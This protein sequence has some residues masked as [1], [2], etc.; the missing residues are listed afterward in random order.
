[1]IPNR[2]SK[3]EASLSRQPSIITGESSGDET[4]LACLHYSYNPGKVTE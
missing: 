2:Y 3:Q 4:L 1:M